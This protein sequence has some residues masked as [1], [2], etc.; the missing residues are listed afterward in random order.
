MVGFREYSDIGGLWICQFGTPGARV[1]TYITME[2]AAFV[3]FDTVAT[4]GSTRGD[5]KSVV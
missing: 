4:C 5:R 1:T 2:F 3:R